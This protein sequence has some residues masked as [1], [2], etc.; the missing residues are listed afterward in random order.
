MGY[1]ASQAM[2]YGARLHV[3]TEF[4]MNLHRQM[5]QNRCGNSL[6]RLY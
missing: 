2:G 5:V 1:D 3:L 6:G 4:S